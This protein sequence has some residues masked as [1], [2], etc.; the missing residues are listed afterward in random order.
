MK[1]ITITYICKKCGAEHTTFSDAKS[2]PPKK[3]FKCNGKEFEEII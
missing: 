3:C 2:K 1:N